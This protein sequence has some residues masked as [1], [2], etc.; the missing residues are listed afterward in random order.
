MEFING[1]EAIPAAERAR[2][3]LKVAMLRI[4]QRKYPC[5]A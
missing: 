4:L 1:L 5:P 2:M 3:S